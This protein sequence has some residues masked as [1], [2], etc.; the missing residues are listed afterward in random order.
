MLFR[1]ILTY[2]LDGIDID[3]EYPVAGG[4]ASNKKRKEDKTNFTLLL[5]KIRT[6]LTELSDMTGKQYYL[7]IAGAATTEYVENVELEKIQEYLDYIYVMT[8]DY[9]GPWDDKTGFNAPIYPAASLG[10]T[11]CIN[12]TID[13]YINAGVDPEKMV[14]GMPLYGYTYLTNGSS[15]RGVDLNFYSSGSASYDT[16][17]KNYIMLN[18]YMIYHDDQVKTSYM[19]GY[20][21]YG[22]PEFVSFDDP[23]N[24]K[25]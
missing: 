3:W 19:F 16:I 9:Y 21:K 22:N 14:L 18:D 10:T 11:R 13:N 15:N 2:D 17:V 5:K 4:L 8:Y 1:S 7:T 23:F 25:N 6:E 24:L 12:K 20:N